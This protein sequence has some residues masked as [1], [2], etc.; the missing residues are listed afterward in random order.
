MLLLAY[1]PQ[2]KRSKLV[3]RTIRIWYT[4]TDSVTGYIDKCIEDVTVVKS[5]TTHA[6]QKP[7]LMAEICAV[8]RA[9]IGGWSGSQVIE[10]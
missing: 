9:Q 2:L 10:G 6:N 8:L 1:R 4:D 5:I 7:W 3:H